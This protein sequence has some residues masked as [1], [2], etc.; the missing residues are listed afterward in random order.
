M[1]LSIC[2]CCF[3][4]TLTGEMYVYFYNIPGLT[5]KLVKVTPEPGYGG[6]GLRPNPNEHGLARIPVF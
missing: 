2:Y 6:D 5:A 1:D 4:I 3:D